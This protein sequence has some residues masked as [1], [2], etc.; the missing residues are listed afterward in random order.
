MPPDETVPPDGTVPPDETALPDGTTDARARRPTGA[1]LAARLAQRVARRRQAPA[2]HPYGVTCDA[3]LTVRPTGR[4]WGEPWLDEPGEYAVRLRW[5]RAVGLPGRLP[6]ALGLAVRVYDADGPGSLLDLLLTSSGSGR[7]T[8]HLPLPR[9]DALAGPYSTLLPYRIGGQEA[10]LAVHPVVT[11]PL[12]PNTL[13][14]LRAAVEAEPLAFDLCA[15]PPGRAWRALGTLTTGPLH[16]RP[17]DDRVAYDPYLNRLP[18]L[19][20]TA[21]LSGLREAAYAASRRG[22]GAADPTEP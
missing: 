4:P 2:L 9:L 13:A 5:S 14:R 3:L 22:R 17:P 11:S 18:H 19:R 21:W 7:R 10:L 12:V 6:D 20:P 15:A 16:D 8:R 1:G